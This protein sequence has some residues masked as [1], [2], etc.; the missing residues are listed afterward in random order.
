MANLK[1]R[2][3]SPVGQVEDM[4]KDLEGLQGKEA[5][6]IEIEGGIGSP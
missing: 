5:Q 2:L 4:R 1:K 3:A 6:T